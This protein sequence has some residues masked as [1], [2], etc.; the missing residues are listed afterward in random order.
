MNFEK[1]KEDF[2]EKYQEEYDEFILDESNNVSGFN[3]E[4][5]EEMNDSNYDSY[6]N[7]DSDIYKIFEFKDYNCYV[8][9][10]GNRSSYQGEEWDK[11]EEVKPQTKVITNFEPVN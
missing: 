2:K 11:M 4:L 6:G 3:V 7:E 9:F 5:I 10:S 8:R 1:L